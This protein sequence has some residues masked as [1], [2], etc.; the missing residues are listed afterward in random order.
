MGIFVVFATRT[1]RILTLFTFIVA[2]RSGLEAKVA[3]STY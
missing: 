3:Q 1:Y 2:F